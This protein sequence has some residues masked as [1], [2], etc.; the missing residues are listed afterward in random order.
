MY[1]TTSLFIWLMFVDKYHT[2]GSRREKE[3]GGEVKKKKEMGRKGW[4]HLIIQQ[5]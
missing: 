2:C 3:V 4:F 5:I 1:D